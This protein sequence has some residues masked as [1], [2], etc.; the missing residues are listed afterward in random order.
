MQIIKTS[1]AANFNHWH[2]EKKGF[3]G[4]RS[5]KEVGDN[6]IGALQESRDRA[7]SKTSRYTI[8]VQTKCKYKILLGHPAIDQ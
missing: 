2:T 1:T 3:L 8:A 5:Y 6:F 7:S 4:K